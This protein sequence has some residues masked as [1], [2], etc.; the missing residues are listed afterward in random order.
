V[1]RHCVQWD[2]LPEALSPAGVGKRVIQGEGVSLVMVRV[3][4]GMHAP[5]HSHAREQFVQ[6][7][8]GSG[9]LEMENGSQPFGPGSVFYFPPDTW[10]A[11]V[12]TSD[13]V[14]VETNLHEPGA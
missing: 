2:D 3:P 9:I 8:S 10:H 4:A 13:T 7:L 12:F 11:A 1:A 14:L 6:V 5:R